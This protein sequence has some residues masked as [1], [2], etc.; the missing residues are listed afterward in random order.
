[1]GQH[2]P[3]SEEELDGR[4]AEILQ[5]Y[6]EN[7]D[8]LRSADLQLSSLDNLDPVPNDL[9]A[10][11]QNDVLQPVWKDRRHIRKDLVQAYG[12]AL[13]HSNRVKI[14]GEL[15][16]IRE[17]A[18][19]ELQGDYDWVVFGQGQ[20]NHVNEPTSSELTTGFTGRFNEDKAS[21][22]YGFR[23]I[24]ANGAQFSVT[25]SMATLDSN[26]TF[27][28][29]NPQTSS[30][31]VFSVV[32]PLGAGSG[33]EYSRARLK[34]VKLDAE[35]A[36]AEY[37]RGLQSHLVQ[38]NR[39][40]WQIYL[41]RAAY[42]QRDT[43]VEET[44]Q[45]VADLEKRGDVDTGATQSAL[46]RAQ[47]TL[48]KNRASLIRGE[49]AIYNSEERLRVLLNDPDFELG[50]D[51]EFIPLNSPVL[52]P[53]SGDI[54]STVQSAIYNRPEIAQ[55]VVQMRSAGLRRDLQQNELKPKLD[56]IIEGSVAGNDS[57]RDFGGALGDQFQYGAGWRS[58]LRFED[59]LQG[60]QKKARYLR[61]EYELRQQ[62]NQLRSSLDQV[63]LEGVV[64]YRELLTAYREMQGTWQ[65]LLAAREEVKELKAR[66]DV[67][68]DANNTVGAQLQLILD[69]IERRQAAEE[70]LL[71]SI[72]N[73][74]VAFTSVELAKGSLLSYHNIDIK[75][76]REA[77]IDK[78]HE[79][80]ERIEASL[81]E[82]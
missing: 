23:R 71:A 50:D 26:S 67:D 61:R 78:H 1:A 72:V 21:V 34:I 77:G 64:T 63:V 33:V 35:M 53:P 80:L 45:I 11:W 28:D 24:L 81:S 12:S 37:L 5:E 16:L 58:G 31:L 60:N 79:A 43:L 29:P 65:A 56:F 13:E 59:S 73:Y 51:G 3:R 32:Q 15:P 14:L 41:A 68:A 74:N 39:A 20:F 4:I 75:R 66:I 10:S 8:N 6:E 17:T 2:Q 49:M 25:H 48:A 46:L 38:V 44:A 27:L 57:G 22:D 18:I 42:L 82:Q 7:L 54:R 19:R 62:S 36:N 70:A 47:S 52:S 55:A 69:A 9:A 30:G 76:E 40:Y